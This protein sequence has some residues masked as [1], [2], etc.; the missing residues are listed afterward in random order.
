MKI[1]VIRTLFYITERGRE[2]PHKLWASNFF[3][4]VAIKLL[5]RNQTANFRFKKLHLF[6]KK[7]SNP[8][9]F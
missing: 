9:N 5:M 1:F 7:A 4:S 2:Q 3:I 8:K 6:E